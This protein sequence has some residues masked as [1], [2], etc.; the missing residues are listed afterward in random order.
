LA[1]PDETAKSAESAAPADK[2]DSEPK[3]QEDEAEPYV[4]TSVSGKVTFNYDAQV[5]EPSVPLPVADVAIRDFTEADVQ[6]VADYFFDG[7]E[8]YSPWE[9]TKDE[10][11]QEIDAL[12]ARNKELLA[13]REEYES[14]PDRK[15]SAEAKM[16]SADLTDMANDPELEAYMEYGQAEPEYKMNEYI[17]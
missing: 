4:D 14:D 17:T 2:E 12:E 5:V 16:E 15:A 10:I 3:E 11:Q 8:T 7:M 9:R 1:A 13:I 6:K